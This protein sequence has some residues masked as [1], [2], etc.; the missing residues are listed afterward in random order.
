[1]A[2]TVRDLTDAPS[3]LAQLARFHEDLYVAG[4]PDPDEQES[5]ANMTR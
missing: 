1:M 4:F 5:L 2:L 3:D